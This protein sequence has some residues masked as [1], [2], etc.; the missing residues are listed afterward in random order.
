MG[1]LCVFCLSLFSCYWFE[2]TAALLH[3]TVYLLQR[4]WFPIFFSSPQS[5]GFVGHLMICAVVKLCVVA[6][7]C[8]LCCAAGPTLAFASVFFLS[9]SCTFIT[10]AV[11]AARTL[12]VLLVVQLS[13]HGSVA[14]THINTSS[15]VFSHLPVTLDPPWLHALFSSWTY[16]QCVC[17]MTPT[18]SFT[19]WRISILHLAPERD[20]SILRAFLFWQFSNILSSSLC[21]RDNVHSFGQ[22][23]RGI[24]WCLNQKSSELF[25]FS[26]LF[27]P[28]RV[29]IVFASFIRCTLP[30]TSFRVVYCIVHIYRQAVLQNRQFYISTNLLR[31]TTF[32]VASI[33]VISKS[34]QYSLKKKIY[35]VVYYIMWNTWSRQKSYDRIRDSTIMTPHHYYTRT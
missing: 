24:P 3:E 11:T 20:V 19:T 2:D 17:C 16:R 15:L 22:C 26:F 18:A 23:I 9:L 4:V 25:S 35:I 6:S 33:S 5:L 32:Q 29:D 14:R 12:V 21:V 28:W 1:I 13:L 27:F 34:N 30:L 7:C 8:C 10:T 31:N